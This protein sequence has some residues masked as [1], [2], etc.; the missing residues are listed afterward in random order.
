MT[1]TNQW[2]WEII[3]EFVYQ[4][5]SFSQFRRSPKL[6]QEEMNYIKD[7]SYIWSVLSVLNVLYSL[8]E[9]SNI[10]AQLKAYFNNENPDEVAGEFGKSP[11]YKMLG[12]FSII[13]LLRVHSML[14]D[15]HLAVKVLENIDLHKNVSAVNITTR[16]FSCSQVLS[17]SIFEFLNLIF[18]DY[19][20]QCAGVSDH[21]L[22]LCWVC[23]RHD[24]TVCGCYSNLHKFAIVHA[25]YPPDVSSKILSE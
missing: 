8:I 21:N 12:Y 18:S 22:L 17:S 5:Q 6:N 9:K 10:N 4:F 11:L 15:Y 2:L 7:H 14:G 16:R 20:L 1:L 13:A 3:D 19:V 25:A 24:E 23:L